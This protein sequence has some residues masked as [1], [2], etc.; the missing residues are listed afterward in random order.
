MEPV[1][2]G[3]EGIDSALGGLI[4]GDNVAWMCDDPDLYRSLAVG[5][6]RSASRPKRRAVFVAF[7]ADAALAIRGVTTLNATPRYELASAGQLVD[8]IERHV[9]SHAPTCLVVDDLGAVVRRWGPDTV[10]AFFERVCPAMLEAGITAYWQ[11]GS[12]LG[13]SFIEHARQI[14]QCLLDVRHG[15]LR[16][17]KAEGRP[18]A[19]Q[20]ISYRLQYDAGR[21]EVVHAPAGG[22]LARG[23]ATTRK[24][25]G[26]SQSELA[27]AAGVT[28]SAISQAESGVRG[29]SLDTVVTLADRLDISVD[30]L[31]STGNPR[32]YHL[33]RHDR[34]RIVSNST[35]AALASDITT[36]LRVF[37]VN[38]PGEARSQPPF[39]HRGV[40]AVAPLRGLVQVELDD[41]RP[42]LRAGDVLVVD[43]GSVRSWRNLKAHAAACYWIV[44]D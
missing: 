10:S 41:D 2:T 21:I 37:L 43:N 18:D 16:V 23:L 34:A 15:R 11:I 26:L 38:L 35:L 8:A 28:A 19:L 3:F 29:L 22:R 36:G 7:R 39:D 42:V 31:L 24:E 5:L 44:R 4:S 25:L 9:K 33:A 20:D 17:L 1:G 13:P 32:S 27:A 6:V 30:R 12:A 14:T 40:A